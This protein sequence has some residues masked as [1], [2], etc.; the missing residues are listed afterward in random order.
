[1]KSIFLKKNLSGFTIIELMVAA[2]ILSILAVTTVQYYGQ[3]RTIARDG[4][5]KTAVRTIEQSLEASHV[6]SGDYIVRLLKN[7]CTLIIGS[8]TVSTPERWTGSGCTGANGASMGLVNLRSLSASVPITFSSN[9]HGG[10]V[11]YSYGQVSI[12]SA[13]RQNGY[14]TSEAKDPQS[15]NISD[16]SSKD[17]SIATFCP[18][19]LQKN[20]GDGSYVAV[21]AQL[22][23]SLTTA[24]ASNTANIG[25]GSGQIPAG[26]TSYQVDYAAPST[27]FN[28]PNIFGVGSGSPKSGQAQGRR[29]GEVAMAR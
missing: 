2:T 20:G 16:P 14:L 7:P 29:C 5:R 25:G 1:M 12:A 26:Y 18:G 24:D 11:T 4:N 22:E 13:L 17:Y 27:L 8:G 9:V 19:G 21:Y 23:G 10:V 3:T 28:A 15:T 6:V